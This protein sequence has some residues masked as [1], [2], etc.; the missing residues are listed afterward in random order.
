M[1]QGKMVVDL[2]GEFMRYLFECSR[3]HIRRAQPDGAEVWEATEHKIEFVLTCPDHWTSD[4][5]A[6]LL[7]AALLAKFVPDTVEGRS[8]IHLVTDNDARLAFCLQ[9]EWSAAV[10]EVCTCAPFLRVYPLIQIG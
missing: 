2:L 8:R 7:E 9:T 5:K 4:Q 1:P 10:L 6:R 3:T